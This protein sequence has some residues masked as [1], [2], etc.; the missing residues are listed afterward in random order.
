M[1]PSRLEPP[2]QYL[3]AA[4]RA[5]LQS[6]ELTRLNHAANLRGEI[7]ALVDQWLEETAEAML[8]RWILEHYDSFRHPAPSDAEIARVTHA[9]NLSLFPDA[10]SPGPD[11]RPAQ[12]RYASATEVLHARLTSKTRR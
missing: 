9:A 3:R 11:A 8:A 1:P 5:S 10:S 4:S 12:P 7:G 2:L 6:F